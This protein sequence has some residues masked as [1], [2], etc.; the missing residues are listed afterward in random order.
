M[1][2][3][4]MT[5]LEN[6][7]HKVE[8]GQ[9]SAP[10]GLKWTLTAI[11]ENAKA[12]LH[13]T[14][15]N[16][17]VLK[18]ALKLPLNDKLLLISSLTEALLSKNMPVN[19]R[20]NTFE[21]VVSIL[22]HL[23]PEYKTFVKSFIAPLMEGYYNDIRKPFI[24]YMG[25][26]FRSADGSGNSLLIPDVGKAGSYYSRTVAN[27]SKRNMD[28]LP[29]AKD[30]F[31]K[32]LR[33]PDGKFSKN[34]NG[35]NML[36]FYIAILI[37]HDLFHSDPQNPARNLTT[38]YID[39][40]SLYGNN[41]SEQ[42]AVRQMKCGLLKPDQWADKRLVL[43]IPGVCALMVMFS[44]NHNHIAKKL[45]EINE[46]ERFSYGIGKALRNQEEQDEHLFQTARL[47]NNA[48]Y[49]NI[50]IHE[51][52]RSISGAD[53]YADFVLFDPKD[54]PFD[55]IYGNSVSYEFNII[56]RWHAALGEKDTKWMTTVFEVL[57][58]D[59]NTA[60]EIHD[61]DAASLAI[62]EKNDHHHLLHRKKEE[63]KRPETEK[64]A[65]SNSS[66]QDRLYEKFCEHFVH[67][68]PEE[69]E[70]GFPIAGTHRSEDGTFPD[71]DLVQFLKDGYSQNASE[72]GNGRNTP[73]AL[74]HVEIA[75][76][77]QARAL[78]ICTFND[79][80]RHFNLMPLQTFEDFSEDIEVQKGLQELYGTPENVELFPGLLIE[81][82]KPLGIRFP[83]TMNRGILS[84][85]VNL[86]KND[87]FIMKEFI[88]A[89]LTNWGYDYMLG[90]PNNT[91]RI[92]PTLL[93]TLF[94]DIPPGSGFSDEALKSPFIVPNN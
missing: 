13:L 48:C 80:R 33:R 62:R 51:Y 10:V 39:L 21:T 67:A 26:Q 32:L 75:G 55:P 23:G 6:I 24:S 69:L 92:L 64:A 85:A 72:L 68:T 89:N 88:P 36:L 43:Q 1:N 45:L 56:Y 86:L 81:Q 5:I 11:V 31:D 4:S 15:T 49:L 3:G 14:P 20:N 71:R 29:S 41:R 70:R 8:P 16:E 57:M 83:Y 59:S 47:V 37:T 61:A 78:N 40:S 19:D 38:S 50:V 18:S 82:P 87:R 66:F 91:N 9:S 17:E 74:E 65:K 42:E 93:T 25:Q 79:F 22:C 73:A 94:P 58:G 53:A 44:R 46:N 34:K 52:V 30:V 84:D 12:L 76:I 63:E 54:A 27:T 35:I 60:T 7:S 28:P 77:N 2:E 90:D